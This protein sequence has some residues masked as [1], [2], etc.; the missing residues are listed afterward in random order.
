MCH[1]AAI[2]CRQCSFLLPQDR[3]CWYPSPSLN[4]WKDLTRIQSSLWSQENML[5]TTTT[6]TTMVCFVPKMHSIL[7]ESS[8]TS[9]EIMYE[10]NFIPVRFS[11]WEYF[12]IAQK[13]NPWK[14]ASFY[15]ICEVTAVHCSTQLMP[16]SINHLLSCV[17]LCHVCNFVTCQK[18]HTTSSARRSEKILF[19]PWTYLWMYLMTGRA[20]LTQ[21]MNLTGECIK[22]VTLSYFTS[23]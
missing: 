16:N 5:F 17:I 11:K 12:S 3:T 6:T 7:Y 15:A 18:H 2:D 1:T 23:N 21:W 22:W 9:Q 8:S 13:L 4:I 19:E 20:W 14:F 10:W